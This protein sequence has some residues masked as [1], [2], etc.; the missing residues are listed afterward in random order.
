LNDGQRNGSNRNPHF[1]N[2]S[3]TGHTADIVKSTCLIQSGRRTFRKPI[4]RQVKFVSKTTIRSAAGA[5]APPFGG[6]E[7]YDGID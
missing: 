5:L 1:R 2:Y 3:Q 4:R 7:R 6:N